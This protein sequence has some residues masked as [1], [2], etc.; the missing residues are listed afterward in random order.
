[1]GQRCLIDAGTESS[2]L[3][4]TTMPLDKGPV[5]HYSIHVEHVESTKHTNVNMVNASANSRA[6]II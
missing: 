1:M 6:K 4:M 3:I 2:A 5:D